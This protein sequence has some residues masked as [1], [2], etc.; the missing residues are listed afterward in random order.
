VHQIG[1]FDRRREL[2]R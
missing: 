1:R 2:C